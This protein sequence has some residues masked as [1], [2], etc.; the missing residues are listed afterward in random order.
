M[1][2]NPHPK[3][4]SSHRLTGKPA[5]TVQQ[6]DMVRCCSM[7]TAEGPAIKKGKAKQV[8]HS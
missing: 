1:K 2:V 6:P 3:K 8:L 7:G 4:P 5:A